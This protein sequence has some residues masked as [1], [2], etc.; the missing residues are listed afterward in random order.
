MN[1]ISNRCIETIYF[2][3]VIPCSTDY[4]VIVFCGHMEPSPGN[5]R[6]AFCLVYTGH[7]EIEVLDEVVLPANAEYFREGNSIRLSTEFF[8]V[9]FSRTSCSKM[10]VSILFESFYGETFEEH[11]EFGL[12]LS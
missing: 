4:S 12:K 3:R 11:T 8:D 10:N 6:I 1:K 9:E 2:A 7:K 5:G